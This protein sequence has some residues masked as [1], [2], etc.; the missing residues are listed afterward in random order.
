MLYPSLQHKLC[1]IIQEAK[2]LMR[3][4]KRE[5][6][7]QDDIKLALKSLNMIDVHDRL[8]NYPANW[9]VKFSKLPQNQASFLG[10]QD[11][12]PKPQVSQDNVFDHGVQAA[13]ESTIWFERTQQLDLKQWILNPALCMADK[14]PGKRRDYQADPLTFPLE[15]A[16]Q[17]HFVAIAGV[18]PNLPQNIADVPPEVPRDDDVVAVNQ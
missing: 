13:N 11:E 1:E 17:L 5:H 6:L 15:L 4:G 7:T 14:A 16:Y 18:Q 3:H 9:P 8:F 2:K 10:Q 12:P